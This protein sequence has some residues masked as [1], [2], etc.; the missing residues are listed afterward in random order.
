M[1]IFVIAR[2]IFRVA[3]YSSIASIIMMHDIGS[4]PFF[5]II[6]P[7]VWG[8]PNALII[9]GT[10]ILLRKKK[11]P[12]WIHREM[13]SCAEFF[14]MRTDRRIISGIESGSRKRS[15]FYGMVVLACMAM[16]WTFARVAVWL[17]MNMVGVYP[18]A[19]AIGCIVAAGVCSVRCLVRVPAYFYA[20][21]RCV[22]GA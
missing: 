15:A 1:Q 6:F 22:R 12:L 2:G 18:D 8:I 16:S 9:V 19:F 17:W 5:W 11:M 3:L 7:F 13:R 10:V 20:F 14:S 21:W 4:P